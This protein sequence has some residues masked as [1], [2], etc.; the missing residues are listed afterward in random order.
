MTQNLIWVHEDALRATHPV[1]NKHNVQTDA[2]FIWD[3]AYLQKMDYG[4][5]RL[6]FIYETVTEMGVPIYRGDTVEVLTYLANHLQVEDVRMAN[7]PNPELLRLRDELSTKIPI[8]T[9]SD[10][11]FV[12][13]D[14][15]PKLKRFFG[16][17]KAAAPQLLRE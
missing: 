15:P 5:Q 12:T 17:W 13:L 3:D 11:E 1:M 2:V 10:R 14:R 8:V 4:F 9:V 6:I 16:Y 7:T